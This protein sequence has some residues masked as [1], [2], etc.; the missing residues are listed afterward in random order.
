MDA[1]DNK[2]RV[3]RW[4][5]DTEDGEGGMEL[6]L[7]YSG[8]LYAQ[9]GEKRLEQRSR[10][11]HTIRKVF[12]KQIKEFWTCHPY[13]REKDPT[14][15]ISPNFH[16]FKHDGF[17]WLPLSTHDNGTICRLDILMLRDGTPGNVLY[18]LDNRVKVIFDALRK[19]RSPAELGSGTSG[20]QM[21]PDSDETPFFVLLEND[22]LITHASVAADSLLE[23]IPGTLKSAAVRLVL[24]VNIKQY[25]TISPAV[26]AFV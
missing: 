18:D 14:A 21:T 24:T 8:P 9:Q 25:R 22:D 2:R 5:P 12:H 7:T 6:R 1:P 10:H 4:E 13:L 11:V 26:M 20:G 23:E 17:Q 3:L 19:P 15:D 16:L